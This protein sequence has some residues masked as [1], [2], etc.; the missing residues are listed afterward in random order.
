MDTVVVLVVLVLVMTGLVL[1]P[2]KVGL[3]KFRSDAVVEIP[4]P[5]RV[6]GQDVHCSWRLSPIAGGQIIILGVGPV[7]MLTAEGV[8]MLY[9][10]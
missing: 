3:D 9:E 5:D 8:A 7:L 6:R 1:F 10:S 2:K 4:T